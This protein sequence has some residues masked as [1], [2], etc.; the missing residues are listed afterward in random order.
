MFLFQILQQYGTE[1]VRSITD[2]TDF[3]TEQHKNVNAKER[4]K[5]LLVPSETVYEITDPKLIESLDMNVTD[6]HAAH[7]KTKPKTTFKRRG[8]KNRN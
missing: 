6:E 2:I 3:V 5:D 1:W 4:H 8:N 7:K